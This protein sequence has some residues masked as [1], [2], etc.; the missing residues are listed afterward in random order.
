M[1]VSPSYSTPDHLLCTTISNS[2]W[3]SLVF[4]ENTRIRTGT[5]IISVEKSSGEITVGVLFLGK[6]REKMP[7]REYAEV[8]NDT[9]AGGTPAEATRAGER[10]EKPL[11]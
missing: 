2:F 6:K 3:I 4:L 7:A 11:C 1:Y 9:T 10:L 8:M 5:N